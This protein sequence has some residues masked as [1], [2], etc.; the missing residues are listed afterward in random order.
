MT[1]ALISTKDKRIKFV[2]RLKQILSLKNFQSHES[3]HTLIAKLT[4]RYE[5]DSALRKDLDDHPSMQTRT[6]RYMHNLS[7]LF[8]EYKVETAKNLAN[9]QLDNKY[10]TGVLTHIVQKL[11]DIPVDKR[12]AF[13]H[14]ITE[15]LKIRQ[16]K[17]SDADII[18]TI[19]T[20]AETLFDE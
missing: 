19:D 13:K 9:N 16:G 8:F 15:A 5:P 10:S 12:Y 6:N 2:N 4:H 18:N 20:L 14:Q 11:N 17:P 7:K 3:V 1:A